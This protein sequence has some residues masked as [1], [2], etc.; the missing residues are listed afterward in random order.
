MDAN[1]CLRD[2]CRDDSECGANAACIPRL[3]QTGDVG[4]S[5]FEECSVEC[6]KCSCITYADADFRG[7]CVDRSE[8]LT[9]F[10]CDSR[11]L[12]CAALANW[13]ELLRSADVIW[14]G[15]LTATGIS[16]YA[17]RTI[18]CE[19]Q[20]DLELQERCQVTSKCECTNGTCTIGLDDFHALEW[21]LGDSRTGYNLK[22]IREACPV[23]EYGY[24]HYSECS[25]GTVR[26]EVILF[27]ENKYQLV[28]PRGSDALSYG[29]VDGYVS[30]LCGVPNELAVIST[31]PAPAPSDCRTCAFCESE[32]DTAGEDGAGGLPRCLFDDAGNISLPPP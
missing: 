29:S 17:A 20:L 2:D 3:I 15:D 4:G 12:S 19:D 31:G 8:D 23:P 13:R 9:R 22:A 7:Y 16:S 11:G 6:G 32:W 10:E 28:F 14:P 18:A 5:Q 1:C 25:D 30:E 21:V 24:G 27:G 26:Y